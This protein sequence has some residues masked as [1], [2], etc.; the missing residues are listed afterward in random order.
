MSAYPIKGAFL[1]LPNTNLTQGT[2]E[3]AGST[4]QIGK[5]SHSSS[6]QSPAPNKSRK[7]VMS[8][9]ESWN[10][11]HAGVQFRPWFDTGTETSPQRSI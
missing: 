10:K 2:R 4:S 8:Y 5:V 6:T 1:N 3:A 9:N 7:S 11:S